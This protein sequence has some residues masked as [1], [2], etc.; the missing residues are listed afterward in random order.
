M[1]NYER[2]VHEYMRNNCTYWYWL[3]CL[4]LRIYCYKVSSVE[5]T[6]NIGW[7]ID[8]G[9][10]NWI[11]SFLWSVQCFDLNNECGIWNPKV[12]MCFPSWHCYI[13]FLWRDV[14]KR[15][16]TNPHN[17]LV[18]NTRQ[19]IWSHWNLNINIQLLLPESWCFLLKYL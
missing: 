8:F 3:F 6:T 14:P 18:Q 7:G 13:Y 2:T 17:N 1:L 4:F 11:F 10:H 15:N 19:R 12:H 5:G 9:L 16:T